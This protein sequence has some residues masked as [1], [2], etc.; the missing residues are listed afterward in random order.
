MF[1]FIVGILVAIGFIIHLWWSN[2][3][4]D[5][6]DFLAHFF[7][8]ILI[9]L[10]GFVLSTILFIASSG[11]ATNIAEI[12]YTKISDSEIFA[13]KDNSIIG[14]TCYI[15]C[16][17]ID[18]ELYYYY[19]QEEELGYKAKK[20]QA[21]NAFIQ[22]AEG[23]PHIETYKPG[24]ANAATYFWGGACTAENRYVIYCPE[25]T[26]VNEFVIDLE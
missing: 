11:V 22:C 21:N 13:L 2:L 7:Q 9:L 12:E 26:I 3:I 18:E 10:T 17:Y 4:Y 19:I 1:W 25:G 15:G 16:G 5:W 14:D 6:I 8:S 20:V 23:K 24:F